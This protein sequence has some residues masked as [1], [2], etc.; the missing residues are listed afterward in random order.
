[1]EIVDAFK[2]WSNDPAPTQKIKKKSIDTTTQ[3]M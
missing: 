1:M 2:H 3:K